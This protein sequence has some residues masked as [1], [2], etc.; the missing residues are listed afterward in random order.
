MEKK[1]LI[2]I[3]EEDIIS[4]KAE[5]LKIKEKNDELLNAMISEKQVVDKRDKLK[6]IQHTLKDKHHTK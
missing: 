4:K 1:N 5:E 2:A 3:N 6:D